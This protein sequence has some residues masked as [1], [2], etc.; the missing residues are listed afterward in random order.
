MMDA[1]IMASLGVLV[2]SLHLTVPVGSRKRSYMNRSNSH[3]NQNPCY[4]VILSLRIWQMS[5]SA[6]GANGQHTQNLELNT[7]STPIAL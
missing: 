4:P 3:G 1:T 5:N 6:A 7:G 2:D